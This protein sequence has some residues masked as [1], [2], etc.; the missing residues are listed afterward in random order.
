[1]RSQRPKDLYIDGVPAKKILILASI[2]KSSYIVASNG[3]A[4]EAVSENICVN[5]VNKNGDPKEVVSKNITN[6]A[7]MYCVCSF[8]SGLHVR[9]EKLNMDGPLLPPSIHI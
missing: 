6:L 5:S 2:N 4:K 8:I 3:F 1:M 7:V 9:Q